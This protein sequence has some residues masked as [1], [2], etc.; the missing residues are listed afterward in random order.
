MR[1]RVQSVGAERDRLV[2]TGGIRLLLFTGTD[3]SPRIT[4]TSIFVK[5]KCARA[6][7]VFRVLRALGLAGEDCFDFVD[8]FCGS[9]RLE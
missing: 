9:K 8:Q 5:E 1:D 3:A 4:A 6:R 2:F 7:R